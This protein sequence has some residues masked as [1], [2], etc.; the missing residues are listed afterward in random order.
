M[1]NKITLPDNFEIDKIENGVIYLKEKYKI[2]PKTWEECVYYNLGNYE[3]IN[4]HSKIVNVQAV[5]F[6]PISHNIIPKGLAKPILALSQLLVCRNAYWKIDNNWKPE[7][8]SSDKVYTIFATLGENI[9]KDYDFCSDYSDSYILSFRT[10]EIR[11]EFYNNF[12]DL[13]EQAK[14]LL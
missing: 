13:I 10:A 4:D 11:D 7:V 5:S 6:S 8:H 1:K 3:G 12:K 9:I 2:F 14:E